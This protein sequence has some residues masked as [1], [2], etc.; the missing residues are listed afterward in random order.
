MVGRAGLPGGQAGGVAARTQQCRAQAWPL[1]CGN[2]TLHACPFVCAHAPMHPGCMRCMDACIA[3]V[4]ALH[5][6]MHCM[7][8]RVAC[9]PAVH[10]RLHCM[11]CSICTRACTNVWAMSRPHAC[12]CDARTHVSMHA[13]MPAFP[14]PFPASPAHLQMPPASVAHRP[15]RS[16]CPP[17]MWCL[18]GRHARP[19][20]A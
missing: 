6:R 4:Y 18:K 11:G 9:M 7:G 20:A 15:G 14:P 2:K 13:C 12:I 5:E 17:S 16:A 10:G 1:E 3:W 8:G 19:Q